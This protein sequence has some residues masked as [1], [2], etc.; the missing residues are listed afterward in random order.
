MSRGLKLFY[1]KHEKSKIKHNGKVPLKLGKMLLPTGKC[2]KISDVK[3]LGILRQ[4]SAIEITSDYIKNFECMHCDVKCGKLGDWKRHLLTAKHKK[5]TTATDSSISYP[6]ENCSKKYADRK[7]LW[8]HK[9]KCTQGKPPV[10]MNIENPLSLISQETILEIM[11]NLTIAQQTIIEQQAKIIELTGKQ[12]ITN[13]NNVTNKNSNNTQINISMFLNE[14]CKD[15]ITIQEFLK[16][17]KP[18]MEDVMYLT[19]HGNKEGISKIITNALGQLEITERPLHCT[20]LKRHTTYV[21]HP[22]GWNKEQDQKHAKKIYDHTVHNCS[23]QLNAIL[24]KDPNYYKNGTPE[25]EKRLKMM[26]E[27]YS[28]NN[29]DSILRNIELNVQL[30]KNKIT[31]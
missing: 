8:R 2:D 22:E 25:Y 15:A 13:S 27:T 28:D 30:D 23:T 21:K 16:S 29:K 31:E 3:S 4:M 10:N 20:D 5:A 11:K 1:K 9:K 18:S 17:I 24:E 14:N 6:C 12:T 26:T 19:E 7:G